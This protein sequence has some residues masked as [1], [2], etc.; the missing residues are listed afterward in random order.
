M[1][2]ILVVIMLFLVSSCARLEDVGKA[3]SFTPIDNGAEAQAMQMVQRSMGPQA[4][5]HRTPSLWTGAR[6]SLLGDRR[7]GLQGDILTVVIEIDERAEI[8]NCLLVTGN[9]GRVTR[10][11]GVQL[12]GNEVEFGH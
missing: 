1:T 10:V 6:G 5:P 9:Q 12:A 2:R 4:M 11:Q 3:P 7:A 8:S